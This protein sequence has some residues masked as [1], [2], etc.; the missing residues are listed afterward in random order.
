M[1]CEPTE[2]ALVA[3]VATPEELIAAVPSTVAP[4]LNVTFPEAVF[5]PEIFGET[6]AVKVTDCPAFAGFADEATA[7]VVAA[8]FTV[9]DTTVDVLPANLRSP[10]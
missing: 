8:A 6:V 9:C 10:A 3:K 7:V 2:S 5:A 4:S 1:E